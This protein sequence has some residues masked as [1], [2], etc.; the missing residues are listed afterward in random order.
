MKPNDHKVTD[1]VAIA[2]GGILNPEASGGS[3]K[4]GMSRAESSKEASNESSV[5]SEMDGCIQEASETP[6]AKK[7]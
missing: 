7:V 6:E 3:G 4:N 5:E 1:A 2:Y